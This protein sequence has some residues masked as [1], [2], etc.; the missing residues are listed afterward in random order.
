MTPVDDREMPTRRSFFQTSA[1]ALLLSRLSQAADNAS[2]P[3]F[4]I[5]VTEAGERRLTRSGI[6][7]QSANIEVTTEPGDHKLAIR[8]TSPREN[9]LRLHL[10]WSRPLAET[11]R[12]LGDAWERS[13][14]DLAFEGMQPDRILPWYVLAT[15]GHSTQALGVK[16]APAALCYWQLDPQGISLW[17][18]LRNGGRAVQLGTRELN[19]CEVVAETYTDR[20]PF[21]AAQAFCKVL[22]PDPRLPKQPIYG[23]NNWYYAYGHSSSLD[24]LQD[25]ERIASVSDSKTNRPWMVID[26]GWAPNPTAGPWR[27]GNSKFPDMPALA[28]NMKK[29]GVRPG[30][31]TRPLFT[32]DALA[33]SE[34]L[35]PFTLDPTS[36]KAAAQ[37]QDDFKTV[38]SWGYEL[39]KHDFSTYDLLGRWGFQMNSEITDSNWSF[40][41]RSR[42]NAEIIRDFYKL[43]RDASLDTMLLGCNTVGHLSAGLFEAQRIGDDTSGRDWDRTRKMGV[44]TLAFR[45]PQH[46]SF[47]AI[48]ADCVGLTNQID[49]RLNK[50]W[51]DLL[52]R[53]G[54]PLFVSIAPTAFGPEQKAAVKAAFSIASQ[55][56]KVAE[57]LDWLNN[58]EPEHWVAQAKRLNFNW[59]LLDG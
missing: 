42:T 30:L 45:M 4:A 18:D 48:D 35:R 36:P 16:T 6:K 31:W 11:L 46:N 41:D 3:A 26:D 39:V 23:G 24:I 49:W 51:L 10:R 43:L 7:W 52:A 32:K 44:N 59:S 28:S 2:L 40:H 57:P 21:Q 27:T 9:P 53:S 14:G 13:Y 50:Q 1:A 56:Q 15:D 47:F 19:V 22:S 25:S 20:S 37:I 54:T 29:I 5:L 58:N 8:L 33:P 12:V 17:C 38:I 55:P 34:E